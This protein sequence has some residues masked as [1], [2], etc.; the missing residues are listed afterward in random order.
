M[1][2]AGL[3]VRDLVGVGL[4]EKE[5][6]LASTGW[7]QP[8]IL[9]KERESLEGRSPEAAGRVAFPLPMCLQNRKGNHMLY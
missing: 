4:Q 8:H 2:Y 3:R 7:L 5:G 9:G 1:E 6:E